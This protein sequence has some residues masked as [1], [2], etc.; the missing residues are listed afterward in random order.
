M[1][2]SL[3]FTRPPRP[4]PCPGDCRDLRYV[5][6]EAL[7]AARRT[8]SAGLRTEAPCGRCGGKALARVVSLAPVTLES[9][10]GLPR[11]PP[12]LSWEEYL[13]WRAPL[14]QRRTWRA[15]WRRRYVFLR[16]WAAGGR[17]R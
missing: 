5:E 12:G 8:R 9:R 16:G 15:D 14:L 1:Q 2:V 3:F 11:R 17:V 6:A 13:T 10:G 7:A 4:L